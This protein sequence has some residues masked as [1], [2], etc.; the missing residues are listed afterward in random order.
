MK[1]K[2]GTRQ[3]GFLS[4]NV[5]PLRELRFSSQ[6]SPILIQSLHEC[7]MQM[8]CFLAE[9]EKRRD[10]APKSLDESLEKLDVMCEKER[11]LEKETPI[12]R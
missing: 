3:R 9:V 7:V 1:V 8:C 5:L 10:E 12:K 11:A 6:K 4:I 2:V